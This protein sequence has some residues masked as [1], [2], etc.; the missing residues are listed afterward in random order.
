M[1]GRASARS[2]LSWFYWYKS[3]PSYPA[4]DESDE[5]FT[6]EEPSDDYGPVLAKSN[7]QSKIDLSI[8]RVTHTGDDITTLLLRV[9]N[10]TA[11]PL[12]EVHIR[13]VAFDANGKALGVAGGFV[14]GY[15][16]P[17]EPG[18]A[19]VNF[20]GQEGEARAFTTAKCALEE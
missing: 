2:S 12:N 3:E 17:S 6:A 11:T 1:I 20:I 5:P 16:A 19:E 4:P 15:L 13:C 9:I 18:F 7:E 10:R 8:E 14:P